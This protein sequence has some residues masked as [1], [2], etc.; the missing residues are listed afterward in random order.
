M[1]SLADIQI[2]KDNFIKKGIEKF[3]SIYDYS[4]V[5][6]K[7]NSTDV[8]I[9]CPTHGAFKTTPASHI[10]KAKYGGCPECYDESRSDSIKFVSLEIEKRGGI[11]LDSMNGG[12]SYIKSEK[13]IKVQCN[14][15]NK[16]WTP[17]WRNIK[18]NNRW[19][20]VC[21]SKYAKSMSF[22]DVEALAAE[23][24]LEVLEFPNNPLPLINAPDNLKLKCK[25]CDHMQTKTL[26]AIKMC[27]KE[28]F[29]GCRN[30]SS[31]T[32]GSKTFEEIQETLGQHGFEVLDL[33]DNGKIKKAKNRDVFKIKCHMGHVQETNV[34]NIYTNGLVRYGRI[35]CKEC[36]N[37]LIAKAQSMSYEEFLQRA[38]EKYGQKFK[39][40]KKNRDNWQ[41]SHSK[42]KIVCE[43]HGQVEV[44]ATTF[45]N[46]SVHGCPDCAKEEVA[47]KH[48]FSQE[49][50]EE[51]LKNANNN[52][53]C[54]GKYINGHTH[55]KHK[56]T[57]CNHQWDVVP[58]SALKSVGCPECGKSYYRERWTRE[59]LE[60]IFK[61]QFPSVRP[62]WL[63]N[64][65][66]GFKLEVDCYCEELGLGLEYQG[67][68]HYESV[69][70]FGG[71]R[72]L[73]KNQKKDRVKTNIFMNRQEILWRIDNRLFKMLK[74]E[75][76]KTTIKQEIRK[77]ALSE[78]H[79]PS[80][81]PKAKKIKS[82]FLTES[83]E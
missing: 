18:V 48:T 21:T 76:F 67:A 35:P 62:E 79:T 27:K 11:L 24:D 49:E 43:K 80:W 78:Y 6:Y 33:P 58:A 57:I 7:N 34:Y 71:E 60:E 63:R 81:S 3:G 17:K 69:K 66:T 16:I 9:V 22:N 36:G 19:C 37:K 74:E 13:R 64:P 2:R 75:E 41:N 51:K 65:E 8:E 47:K 82:F 39:Y 40:L 70:F 29:I 1:S 14:S 77:L 10:S 23:L 4:K 15:C 28:D 46:S 54:M 68:Q 83:I 12:K 45:L 5:S 73:L 59:V 25:V 31:F 55:I 42:I 50:Y 38:K 52:I 56:C 26:H 44:Q 53:I 32:K 61:S 72:N 30:C 20:G